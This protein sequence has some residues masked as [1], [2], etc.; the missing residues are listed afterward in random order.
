MKT[1]IPSPAILLSL[2]VAA[3]IFAAPAPAAG[4]VDLA[5]M[6]GWDIVVAPDASPA[7]AYAAEEFQSFFQQASGVKLPIVRAAGRADRHVFI[8][9]G[10]GAAARFASIDPAKLGAEDFRIV[11]GDSLIAIVGGRPRGTLYGVYSFLEDYLGV[12]FL[13]PD[14]THVPKLSRPARIGPVNRL[15]HPPLEYR[16]SSYGETQRNPDFAARIRNNATANLEAKHGGR[17]RMTLINHSFF[18]QVPSQK[19]GREHPEYFAE[20]NGIRR[21]KTDNDGGGRGTQLCLTNSDVLRIVTEAVL[22]RL[23][24]HPETTNISVSQ[25][26]NYNYCRCRNCRAIDQREGSHMG[27]LLTFV[28]AVAERVEKTHPNVKIGTLAY[29]YTRK[30]PRTV[31]PRRNVQI[32]LC[33]IECCQFHPLE[34]ATCPRNGPF[35][36]DMV[37]WGKICDDIRIWS[38]NTNFRE[39]MLPC[40]NLRIIQPNIRYFVKN[41]ARGVHMQAAGWTNAA[42]LSDLRNYV[43]SRLLWDPTLDGRKLIDEFLDLHYGKAGGPIRRFINFAHD[44]TAS[45]GKH[46]RCNG[47]AA[48]FAIDAAI[49]A[50]AMKAFKDA[51]KLA[52]S[53]ELRTRVE[54]ASLCALRAAIEPIWRAKDPRQLSAAVARRLRPVARR[55]FALCRKHRVS[56]FAEHIPLPKAELRVKFLLGVKEDEDI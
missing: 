38:Y 27:S 25:N 4:P 18:R 14:H 42:E 21:A 55:F 23:A 6:Q 32:Q 45:S 46:P 13:A 54:K 51:M 12:R 37:G 29:Q 10:Q 43:T 11:A 49:T 22:K 26:D 2:S 40:P 20:I 9:P 3:A 33:S 7:E 56:R 53:D 48:D 52:D 28:N 5:A 39:Y 15:Y 19:Y 34:D 41:H 8:G 35:L 50:A 36:R 44:R 47:S 31:R 1:M 16:Y 24:D 17:A 30:P